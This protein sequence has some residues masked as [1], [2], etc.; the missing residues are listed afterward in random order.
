MASKTVTPQPKKDNVKEYN[1]QYYHKYKSMH[2]PI[3]CE[4]CNKNVSFVSWRK[5]LKTKVHNGLPKQKRKPNLKLRVS[6][7]I[8]KLEKKLE[9]CRNQL[10]EMMAGGSVPS[11]I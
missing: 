11:K 4:K 10:N 5:H 9:E 1:R 2:K 7:Q 8:K 3:F 6:N